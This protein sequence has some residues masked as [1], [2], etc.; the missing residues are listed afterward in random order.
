MYKNYYPLTRRSTATSP[1]RGEVI[2]VLAAVPLPLWERSSCA[3]R[4]TGEGSHDE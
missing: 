3:K 2:S 1:T 4:V